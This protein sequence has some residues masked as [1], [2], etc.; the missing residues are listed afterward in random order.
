MPWPIGTSVCVATASASTPS[1]IVLRCIVRAAWAARCAWTT[2]LNGAGAGM[3]A[4][5]SMPE[6]NR[7]A[8]AVSAELSARERQRWAL[9]H[10]RTV[11]P[12]TVRDY[13]AALTVSPATA[14][15]D[16]RALVQREL[17]EALGTTN[18]R[19]SSL[20]IRDGR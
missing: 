1:P 20:R 13:A 5:S 18:D 8:T 4:P 11:G 16:L 19:R 2:C 7:L 10:L 15:R 9:E 12:R 17:V 3:L 14:L 6:Q